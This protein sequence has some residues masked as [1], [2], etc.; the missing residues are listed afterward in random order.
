MGSKNPMII[1][2]PVWIA[3]IIAAIAGIA[4]TKLFINKEK[5]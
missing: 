1:L 5:I 2:V 4:I 3:T